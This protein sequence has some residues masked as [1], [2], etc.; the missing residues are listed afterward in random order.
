[1]LTAVHHFNLSQKDIDSIA[2]IY[3]AFYESGPDLRYSMPRSG[4]FGGRFFP[5]YA[6]LMMETDSE[7]VQHSYLATEHN[8]EVLR[9]YEL[10]NLIVPVVGDFGG[11]K[12]LRS[13]AEYLRENGATIRLFYTS[14]V[15]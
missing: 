4:G 1:L 5:S 8:Y 3:R 13:V 11:D 7:G 14:N 12:A 15:E 9:S 2:Y 6:E 10:K